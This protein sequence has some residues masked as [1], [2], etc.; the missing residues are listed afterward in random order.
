MTT[1]HAFWLG[2]LVGPAIWAIIAVPIGF[3]VMLRRGFLW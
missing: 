1:A 2:V 3:V